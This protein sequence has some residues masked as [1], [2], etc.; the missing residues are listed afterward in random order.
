MTVPE[1]SDTFSA[2]AAREE[3]AKQGISLSNANPLAQA[4]PILT[5]VKEPGPAERHDERML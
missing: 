2:A 4:T 1:K 5:P 3:T